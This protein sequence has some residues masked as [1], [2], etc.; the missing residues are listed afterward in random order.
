MTES[1]IRYTVD[2]VI[3]T[4]RGQKVILDSDLARI[5]GVEVRRLNEQVKRNQDRFPPDFMFR[6]TPEEV[7]DLK[8]Q[9]ATSSLQS[10]DRLKDTGNRSQI[11]TGSARSRSQNASLR[12]GDDMRSQIAT[13]SDKRN[14]RFLPY[15]FTEHGAIMAATVLNSPQAVEMSV[16]VVRAFVKMREQLLTTAT[17][18]QRL[19]EVE[20]TLLTHDSALRDLYQRLR[21]L[22]LPPPESTRKQIGFGVKERRAQYRVASRTP[23]GGR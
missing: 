2:E 5:Y 21:P 11:A 10:V 8:S 19:A 3:R 7:M 12:Q 15:A 14:I 23:R 4:I 13:A 20:R 17:L 16:F 6:L 22:L 18:A 1:T 9:N